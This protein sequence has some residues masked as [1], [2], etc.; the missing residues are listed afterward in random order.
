MKARQLIPVRNFRLGGDEADDARDLLDQLGQPLVNDGL[1]SCS[2]LGEPS[3]AGLDDVVF[4]LGVVAP[5]LLAA[6][7]MVVQPRTFVLRKLFLA[8]PAIR[9]L[10]WK[11]EEIKL[12]REFSF[13]LELDTRYQRMQSVI[14]FTQ[15]KPRQNPQS[16]CAG[17]LSQQ[18]RSCH[19]KKRRLFGIL[20]EHRETQNTRLA[21]GQ[22]GF[23]TRNLH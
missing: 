3:E 2:G 16:F 8:D 10:V 5:K 14:S 1:E 17:I 13:H 11:N 4:D 12:V 18:S 9:N 21:S 23:L 22:Q 15:V 19:S 20:P 7:H 6:R